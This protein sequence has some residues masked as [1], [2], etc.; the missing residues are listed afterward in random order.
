ML[1][2]LCLFVGCKDGWKGKGV[3]RIVRI[4]VHVHAFALVL[5]YFVSLFAAGL[6]HFLTHITTP[7]V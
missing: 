2:F 5:P 3:T 1:W 7:V 6:T 4:R